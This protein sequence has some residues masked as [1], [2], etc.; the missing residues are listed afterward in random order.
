[1]TKV[2]CTD[3][4]VAGH[5]GMEKNHR[6][7]CCRSSSQLC[8]AEE[9]LDLFILSNF[10]VVLDYPN[11]TVYSIGGCQGLKSSCLIEK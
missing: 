10:G 2:R 7:E 5:R 3:E 9:G 8:A 1:M 4:G 6:T 11:I